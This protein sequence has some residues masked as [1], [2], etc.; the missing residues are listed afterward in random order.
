MIWLVMQGFVLR[1]S[2]DI[3]LVKESSH[4]RV[5]RRFI[6]TFK[7][8]LKLKMSVLIYEPA[9][10]HIQK[11]VI[12]IDKS[13]AHSH[14][15]VAQDHLIIIIII[16][17]H[18]TTWKTSLP[19]CIREV[20]GQNT[21]KTSAIRSFFVFFFS[22]FNLMFLQHSKAPLPHVWSVHQ[23]YPMGPRSPFE[24]KR[25]VAKLATLCCF[26]SLHKQ[27]VLCNTVHFLTFR[28]THVWQEL[29]VNILRKTVS[30]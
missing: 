29:N 24:T 23:I 6:R 20:S 12:M 16:L 30:P 2:T 28:E 8:K 3:H 15:P 11:M 9:R 27:S 4:S 5:T 17:T 25:G 1:K 26:N 14:I 22:T 7:K 13:I 21:A 18:A 10:C 19:L